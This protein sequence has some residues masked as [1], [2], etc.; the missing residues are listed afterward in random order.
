MSKEYTHISKGFS[1]TIIERDGL[2]EWQPNHPMY[3][4]HELNK[5]KAGEKV[6]CYY[7]NEQLKRTEAQNRYYWGV[8]L[9]MISAETGND[10]DDLHILFKG[11]FLSKGVVE[12]MGHKI[13]R[14]KS[15]TE[16]SAGQ[17]SEYIQRI[18][19]LTGVL[20]PPTE[21]YNFGKKEEKQEIEYPTEEYNPTF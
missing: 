2:R 7:T 13:R 19:E 17:F 6:T 14:A 21:E 20:A 8:Y 3:I 9:P 15:T 5:Y 4:R 1:G 18:E 16:L 10:I 11:K 12:V